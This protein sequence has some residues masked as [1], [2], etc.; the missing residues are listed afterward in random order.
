MSSVSGSMPGALRVICRMCAT[1]WAV[2]LATSPLRLLYTSA[3]A[4]NTRGK[5][6]RP[7]RSSGGK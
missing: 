3:M 5:D 2:V 7:P 4:F 6:G 1:T